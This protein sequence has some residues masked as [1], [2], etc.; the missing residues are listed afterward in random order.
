MATRFWAFT[1]P[2]ELTHL[3]CCV[4]MWL[5]FKNPVS[6]NSS[7]INKCSIEKQKTKQK[8][9]KK[10]AQKIVRQITVTEKIGG[11]LQKL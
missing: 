11:M 1:G 2:K 6:A 4:H 10:K 3:H 7:D 9:T 8:E 5:G